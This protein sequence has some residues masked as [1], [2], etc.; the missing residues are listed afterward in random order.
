M[1][2][3]GDGAVDG[4]EL[5]IRIARMC[6]VVSNTFVQGEKG[7]NLEESICAPKL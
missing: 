6:V 2:D 5:G 7:Q 3:S 1:G 4:V